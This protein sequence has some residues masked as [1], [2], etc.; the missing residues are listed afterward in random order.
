[1]KLQFPGY[2]TFDVGNYGDAG[3]GQL[4]VVEATARSSNTA[5]AQIMKDTGVETAVDMAES[6]GI[7]TMT[8]RDHVP[9]AVLG[10]ASVSVLDMAS[11][12]STFADN[13]E[14]VTPTVVTRVTNAQGQ[15][16][17]EAP[18]E[19]TRVLSEHTAAAMNWTLQQVVET[20]TGTA[21][22]Y[23]QSV[24]GKTGTTDKYHDAW[25]VGYTCKLTAAVWVGYAQPGPDGK[26]RFMQGVHGINVAG[27]TIP[28]AIWRR[29]M[30]KATV[31]L[32]SCPY[33]RPAD[34][35]FIP[36]TSQY[37]PGSTEAPT[38]TAA[39]TTEPVGTTPPSVAP[40][41]S[42]T[43]AAPVESTTTTAPASTTT[44]PPASTTTSS[45]KPT[46]TTAS[47]PATT[48]TASVPPTTPTTPVAPSPP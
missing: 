36:G 17:W 39:P 21:A 19:R 18:F 33:P 12:Y 48:T 40:A 45:Q 4:N 38:G 43:T 2:G 34:I 26:Q 29:F 15:V 32:D 28:T 3:L 23:G 22:R 35:G 16:L 41:S 1:M 47:I 11:A 9:A 27:G 37:A 5:Y 25:F 7:T 14:H 30:S 8:D 13:G 46:T 31:G 20:G 6:L 44:A 10:T 42:S 24:A